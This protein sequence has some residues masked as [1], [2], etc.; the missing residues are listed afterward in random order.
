MRNALVLLAVL[1]PS[2]PSAQTTTTVFSSATIHV[3]QS[4]IHAEAGRAEAA[5]EAIEMAAA[6]EPRSA[7][8]LR[9]RATLA[10][11]AGKY[12]RAQESYRRLLDLNP[13]DVDAALGLARVNAWAGDTDAAVAMYRKYLAIRG[14]DADAWIE[15]ARA[16]AWR[17]NYAASW[18]A[19]DEYLVRFGESLAYARERAAV[20]ARGGRPRAALP[21]I[22][23]LL[24]GAPADF[25]LNVS[26]TIAL[27]ARHRRTE[28]LAASATVERLGPEQPETRDA[29]ALVRTSVASTGE[30]RASF[31]SDSDGLQVRRIDPRVSVAVAN[32]LR[33]DAGY[34][35]AD[36]RAR[37]GSGLEQIG[38]ATRARHEL[39]WLGFSQR[40]G[41]FSIRAAAGYE[42][43]SRQNRVG[44]LVAAAFVSDHL[45]LSASRESAFFVVS[46]RTVGLG[47]TRVTHGVRLE[48]SPSFRDV[49]EIEG[50]YDELSDGNR[51]WHALV[52]PRRSMLRTQRLNFD[53]G[54]QLR[55]FG[56]TQDF[57]NGY[58]D[59]SLYESYAV[60]IYPY[61][62]VSE[63]TGLGGFAAVG[64]QRADRSGAFAPGA[65]AAVEATFGIYRGW[66][67]KLNGRATLNERLQ[68]GAFRGFGGQAVLVRRF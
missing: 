33:V 25:G 63:S 22:D 8:I 55:Q 9:R 27:A 67:L 3:R 7:D 43:A 6:L 10:T 56:T 66:M 11:W 37:P 32:G 46:P 5:L 36:L 68:S 26:R 19:L 54:V 42:T 65:N 61:W 4:E 60:V 48:W 2:V 16:E 29:Q 35:R 14:T 45:Q 57:D 17:G 58:Y 18:S 13:G 21:I 49:V 62:K 53:L 40:V 38:G 39:T 24:V 28:A 50:T 23:R 44:Y 34:E 20:L 64:V 41:L 15:L 47:I 12:G 30:P 31:Y 1:F 52:A 51:R 59:P